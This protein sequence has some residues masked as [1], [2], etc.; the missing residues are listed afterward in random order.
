MQGLHTQ[1]L[2]ILAR[3][4]WES[5]DSESKSSSLFAYPGYRDPGSS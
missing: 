3:A 4:T 2:Q 5:E 1:D